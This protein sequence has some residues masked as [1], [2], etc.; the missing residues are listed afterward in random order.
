MARIFYF[1]LLEIYNE[2]INDLLAR[3]SG[4]NVMTRN[5]SL[6]GKVTPLVLS[7]NEKREI[8]CCNTQLILTL[9]DII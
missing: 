7:Q 8:F 1:S 6:K 4:Q 2:C 9:N 3:N 5:N